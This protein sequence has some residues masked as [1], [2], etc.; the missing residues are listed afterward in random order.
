MTRFAKGVIL[1]SECGHRLDREFSEDE[2][3]FYRRRCRDRA[4]ETRAEFRRLRS[5]YA[6]RWEALC[7]E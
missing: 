2:L 1:P 5:E 7:S 3:G 4:D 6:A